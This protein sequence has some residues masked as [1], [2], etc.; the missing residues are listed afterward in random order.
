MRIISKT[1]DYYDAA[2]A[3]GQDRSL[4][5][6]R[7]TAQFQQCQQQ[8]VAP[9]HLLAFARFAQVHTPGNMVRPRCGPEKNVYLEIDF[10]LI[11]FAGKLHPFARLETRTSAYGQRVEPIRI[12]YTRDE[13]SEVLDALEIDLDEH[14]KKMSK[15]S[16]WGTTDVGTAA[17]FALSGSEKLREQATEH[18]LAVASWER[19]GDVVTENPVLAGFQMF[20]HLHAWQAFQ[21]LS[22]FWGNLAAPDRVP[23]NVADKDRVAQHGFDK[24]SFRKMP[25]KGVPVT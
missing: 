23:V 2:Q 15:R 17:F 3:E 10:G 1:H 20:K 25:T 4:V 11:L 7:E 24:W 6:L 22:M 12:V 8:A 9:A 13:L 16:V 5:F 18:R 21:E 14:D 19:H